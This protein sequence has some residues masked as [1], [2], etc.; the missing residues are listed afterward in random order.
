MTVQEIL[1]TYGNIVIPNRIL[2]QLGIKEEDVM[3]NAEEVKKLVHS[4]QPYVV[5]DRLKKKYGFSYPEKRISKSILSKEYGLKEWRKHEND[6]KGQDYISNLLDC[7]LLPGMLLKRKRWLVDLV[8]R[9]QSYEAAE[10][11]TYKPWSIQSCWRNQDAKDTV[12]DFSNDSGSVS[13]VH[14]HDGYR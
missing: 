13:A 1:D 3:L 14:D 6:N 5:I 4:S 10:P 7:D 8:E 11:S 2:I 12:K 9:R